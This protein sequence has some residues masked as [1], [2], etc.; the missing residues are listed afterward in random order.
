MSTSGH[1]GGKGEPANP[2]HCIFQSIIKNILLM[3][4]N[5]SNLFHQHNPQ[6]IPNQRN[7]PRPWQTFSYKY[8]KYR[9][10]AVLWEDN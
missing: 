6:T 7:K 1:E 2:T 8:L 10:I 4:V 9:V 5:T 3:A